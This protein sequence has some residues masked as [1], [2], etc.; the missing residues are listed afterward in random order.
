MA[1]LSCKADYGA[2]NVGSMNGI[3]RLS[4]RGLLIYREGSENNKSDRKRLSYA[5]SPNILFY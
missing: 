2:D 4:T 1:V 5:L 3:E